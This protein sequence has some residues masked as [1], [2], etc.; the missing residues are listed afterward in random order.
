MTECVMQRRG[1]VYSVKCHGH[2]TGSEAVCAAISC[3]LCTASAYTE[4][5]TS[6]VRLSHRLQPADALISWQGGVA[7][8]AVFRYIEVGMR[9]LSHNNPKQLTVQI[10]E[11]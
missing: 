6:M 11:K 8:E 4:G 7:A 9:L 10:I 1:D 3:L 5:S 2:A